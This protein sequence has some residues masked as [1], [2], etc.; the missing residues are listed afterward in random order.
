MPA[1]S[2]RVHHALVIDSDPRTSQHSVAALLAAGFDVVAAADCQ[3]ARLA[4]R[5][6]CVELIVCDVYVGD[7]SGLEL[8]R[9][10]RD[11]PAMDEVPVM[12][13]SVSQ[14]TDIIRR[15]HGAVG[16]YYL[17]KPADAQVLGDLAR[18]AVADNLRG[19]TR[20]N[21]GHLSPAAPRGITRP[22]S[23][24]AEAFA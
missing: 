12:F 22:T 16:T 23:P 9:E 11:M 19:V 1:A 10:L 13:L 15:V 24:A 7:E 4:V 21:R 8:T 14:L 3:S 17:R 6:R 18:A 20:V 2:A 5:Q